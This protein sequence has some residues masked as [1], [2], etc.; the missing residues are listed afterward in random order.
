MMWSVV[1]L[2]ILLVSSTPHHSSLV[3]IH[4]ISF[5]WSAVVVFVVVIVVVVV[6]VFVVLAVVIGVVAR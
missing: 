5:Y 6:V 4:W 3:Y 2:Y 1:G